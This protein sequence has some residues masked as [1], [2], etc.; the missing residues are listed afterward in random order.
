MLEP[1]RPGPAEPGNGDSIGGPPLRKTVGIMLTMLQS[2]YVTVGLAKPPLAGRRT[3]LIEI[4]SEFTELVTGL[5][6]GKKG[7]PDRDSPD[8][9][10]ASGLDSI[11]R[12][13]Q[14]LL[15]EYRSVYF[16]A[17]KGSLFWFWRLEDHGRA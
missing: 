2:T 7:L 15:D 5:G 3:N 14:V 12:F 6:I 11:E 9:W 1:V 10:G 13:Y 8:R 4:F 16:R 17:F